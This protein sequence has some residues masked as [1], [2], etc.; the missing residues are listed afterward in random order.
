MKPHERRRSQSGEAP[1]QPE[2]A[3]RNRIVGHGFEA[4]DQLLASPWTWRIHP[5]TQEAAL[6]GLLTE[7]GWVRH[8]LVNR[9]SGHVVDGHLRVALAI[10]RGEVSVPVEYVE[11]EPDE[12]RKI[13]A[14]LDPLAGMAVTD[15]AQLAALL[16]E[17]R[18]DDEGLRAMFA[19]LSDEDKQT[20]RCPECGAILK[21]S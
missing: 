7:V 12:E 15:H 3:F 20:A 21:P 1:A 16:Q 19:K 13:L 14:S 17:V 9:L 5:H 6:E 2:G 18:T 8:I 10:S 11:L 4:P